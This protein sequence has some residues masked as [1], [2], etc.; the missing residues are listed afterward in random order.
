MAFAL[1]LS[2][3]YTAFGLTNVL[4]S[5]DQLSSFFVGSFAILTVA[6]H[7]AGSGVALERSWPLLPSLSAPDISYTRHR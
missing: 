6:N 7:H 2:G 3:G 5:Q 1:L 4:F